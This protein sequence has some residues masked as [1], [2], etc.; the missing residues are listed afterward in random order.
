MVVYNKKPGIIMRKHNLY[1]FSRVI[2]LFSNMNVPV[3]PTYRSELEWLYNQARRISDVHN[4]ASVIE[5]GTLYGESAI[6]IGMGIKRTKTVFEERGKENSSHLISLDN[7]SAYIENPKNASSPEEIRQRIQES[8]L[9]NSVTILETDDLEYINTLS[10]KTINMAWIDSLHSYKH[11]SNLLDSLLPK[12]TTNSLLCG[13][14]Y[15]ALLT[16][17]VVYAIEDFKK[18]YEKHLC[19]FGVHDRIWWCLI[20]HPIGE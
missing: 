19:G 13:H 3:G 2:E 7:Y 20:R 8:G 5:C 18:K 9:H 17:S 16:S 4:E 10:N 14:E 1:K 11:V 12:M 6:A 15:N